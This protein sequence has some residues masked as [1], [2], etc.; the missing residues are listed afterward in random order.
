MSHTGQIVVSGLLGMAA[1]AA[2]GLVDWS[3]EDQ[4]A[5][6]QAERDAELARLRKQEMIDTKEMD[7]SLAE[8]DRTKRQGEM[9]NF[10]TKNAT[11]DP[12]LVKVDDEGNAMPSAATPESPREAAARKLRAAQATG[13]K[14]IIAQAYNELRDL[15]TDEKGDRDERRLD[16]M[17]TFQEK[18]A[19]RQSMLA[20]ATLA[21]QK[22]MQE[23]TAS[24]ATAADKRAEQAAASTQR[25][26]TAT[27]LKSVNDDIKALEKE[28]ADPLLDPAKKKV[29]E[30][31]M[32]SLRN[33]AAGYRATLSNAG[34]PK[35]ENESVT[36]TPLPAPKEGDVIQGMRFKGG[37]PRDPKSW[38]SAAT[39]PAASAPPQPK[40]GMLASSEGDMTKATVAQ[41]YAGVSSGDEAQKRVATEELRRRGLLKDEAPADN[42]GGMLSFNRGY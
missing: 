11:N 26:A 38:E 15:K 22:R 41:L 7:Y 1:G 6:V 4:K 16:L 13:N 30:K 29:I 39:T 14:D 8:R 42:G 10:Y 19:E 20:E 27:A 2:K 5:K 23:I 17:Q 35:T 28:G 31:Q 9:A 18:Q 25:A 12:S 40:A 36:P 3:L 32:A 34:L 24:Q 33:E 37:N 21:H